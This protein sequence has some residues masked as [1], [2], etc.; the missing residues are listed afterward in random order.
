[1]S[2]AEAAPIRPRD[3]SA[4]DKSRTSCSSASSGHLKRSTLV[5]RQALSGPLPH[6]LLSSAWGTLAKSLLPL[7]PSPPVLLGQGGPQSWPRA[8]ACGCP[9]A[10]RA[11]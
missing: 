2:Q 8:L 11:S 6:R 9:T 3:H 10:L 4:A 7:G 1:M 5:H